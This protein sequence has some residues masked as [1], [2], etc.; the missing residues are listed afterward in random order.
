MLYSVVHTA[1][2]LNNVHKKLVHNSALTTESTKNLTPV[3]V[4]PERAN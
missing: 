4:I 1:F 2:P 3:K